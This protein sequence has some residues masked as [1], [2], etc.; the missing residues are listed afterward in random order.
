MR[1]A[2]LHLVLALAPLSL[3]FPETEVYGGGR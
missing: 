2:T 1:I 3:P